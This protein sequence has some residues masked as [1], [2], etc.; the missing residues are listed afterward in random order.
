MTPTP[1]D[2]KPQGAQYIYTD[3]YWKESLSY[4]K[5]VELRVVRATDYDKA[6]ERIEKLERERDDARTKLVEAIADSEVLEQERDT[7][8]RALAEARRDDEGSL[9]A[10]FRDILMQGH[11]IYQDHTRGTY[12]ELSARLDGAARER[13]D[14]FLAARQPEKDA[15]NG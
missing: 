14:E 3:R 6:A 1:L 11:A 10:L 13:V 5:S 9:W 2:A 12:E 15:N 7:A 4:M 8:L